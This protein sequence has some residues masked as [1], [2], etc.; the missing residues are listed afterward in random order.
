MSLLTALTV[1]I[2]CLCVTV[3][4][5][6]L[7]RAAGLLLSDG[8]PAEAR[9]LL[10]KGLAT[11]EGEASAR[12]NGEIADLLVLMARCHRAEGRLWDAEASYASALE[13][14]PSHL[15]AARGRGLV[16]LDLA[17]AA[18]RKPIVR[19]AEIRALA[20]DGTKALKAALVIAPA[21]AGSLHALG[22]LRLLG[23]DFTGAASV[24]RRLDKAEPTRAYPQVL[25]AQALRLS[26]D[27]KGA[28][29]AEQEALKRA[30]E[31]GPSPTLVGDL[32]AL[33]R[34]DEARAA[35]SEGLLAHPSNNAMYRALWQVDVPAGRHAPVERIL[36]AVLE[37]HP[38]QPTALYYLGFARLQA[39]RIDEALE[40]FEE[41]Q[42]VAPGNSEVLLQTGRIQAGKGRNEEAATAYSKTLDA[43][44][45][46]SP[47]WTAALQGLSAIGR[48]YGVGGRFEEAETVF[49]RLCAVE[50]GAAEH[51]INLALSLR[52]LTRFDESEACYR[53]A[54]D[55]APFDGW[56]RNDLGLLY[57]AWGKRAEAT[58]MFLEAREA[59]PRL[60]DPLENLG[61]L[62]RMD[63][64]RS[65]TVAWF[66]D[67]HDRA[68]QFGDEESRRKFRRLLDTCSRE[69]IV[70]EAGR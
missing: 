37:K 35:A 50:D 61:A 41:R 43:A 55:R 17:T 33:D 59:D 48:R 14:E 8:K 69:K 53:K 68:R 7:A 26:G 64:D 67:A 38:A 19:G 52:R 22:Q 39:G 57:L 5:D 63:G 70:G 23:E 9:A 18:T 20:A 12:S 10:E 62:A 2:W 16:F 11:P 56:P 15:D 21:D 44:A 51:W 3:A 30:P 28:L 47:T 42:R 34:I 36:V 27:R 13:R 32:H 66:K 25:L 60:T 54:V 1:S 49:R 29:A 45:E 6:D 24:F 46:G 40:A 58:A 65:G 4:E 31:R